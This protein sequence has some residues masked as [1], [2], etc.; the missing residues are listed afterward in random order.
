MLD[1]KIFLAD[2]D[3][4]TGQ[5]T[6]AT[7]EKCIKQNK[8]KKIKLI[9]TMYLGGYPGNLKEMYFYKRKY[10]CYLIED[11]CH[12]LGATYK[13]KNKKRFI[14]S[15][16]YSDICI[17]SLHPLK[18]ITSG[19]GGI[20]TTKNKKIYEEIKLFRS[21]G[22]I[23]NRKKHWEYDVKIP[24]FNYRLSDINC[25]LA[26]SQLKKIDKFTNYRKKIFLEYKQNLS[27]FKNLSIVSYENKTNPS[28][29][30][31]LLK[32]LV[33]NPLEFKEKL[34]T[35]LKKKSI[36]AQYHYIPIYKFS[37]FKERIKL[38]NTEK[39]YNSTISLP[40]YY[41]LKI[42]EVKKITSYLKNIIKDYAKEI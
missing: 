25:A 23:R 5:I 31:L 4:N 1:A 2:V 40:I 28:F 22:I 42:K 32:F 17:F 36:Y 30:L 15:N 8:I 10:N 13:K 21:H 41:N 29:H 7:L 3:Q 34:L 26:L 35:G 12:A 38:P 20:I 24:G 14:G 37:L 11:A 27:Q 9:I 19:E 6:P 18:T 16:D 39:F 33:S